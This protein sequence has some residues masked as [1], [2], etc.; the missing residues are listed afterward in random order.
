MGV[1]L[2]DRNDKQ[3]MDKKKALESALSQIERQFGKGSIMKM[4]QE[5]ANLDIEATSTGSIGLDVALGIGGLPKGRVVEIYGPESSGKTTLTLHA[6]A[7]EQKKGGICAFVDAEHALD[8]LYAS[9]LGVN[10]D[11]LLISQPDAGEQA[12]EITDTLVRSGAVSIVVV[13]SVAALT[14]RAEMEGDMGD[15]QVGAQARLMSQAMRKLAGSISKSGCMV[16][17]INQIRMKIGVMFGSPETTSGGN[18]LKFY[19]SVRLDIRRIGA[20]KEREEVVGN[21][22]RVKVVKN[23]VAPPFKQV[24]FD[25][26]Y[27]HGISKNGELIDLGN[28][29]GIIEKAGAWYSYGDLRIGQGR[30]NAKQYMADNPDIAWEVEDKIRASYG[31]EFQAP[32]PDMAKIAADKVKAEASAATGTDGVVVEVAGAG[33]GAPKAE[34]DAKSDKTT[35]A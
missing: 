33:A 31:L 8:P 6:I 21:A 5:G 29:I 4:G 18:A 7:E 15:H 10:V 32:K 3:N 27:G 12:L 30:E 11:E 26:M 16:I 17:F 19:A 28:K 14:P 35:E 9:K 34:S 23:K 13:D 2:L 1:V 24:E 25:I 20:I 22:T